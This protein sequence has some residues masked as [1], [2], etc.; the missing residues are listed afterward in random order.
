MTAGFKELEGSDDSLSAEVS[1]AAKQ[2]GIR[3]I[4]PIARES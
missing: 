1:N 3:F 4:G 2:L